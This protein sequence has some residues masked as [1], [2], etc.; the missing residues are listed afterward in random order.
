MRNLVLLFALTGLAAAPL[1]AQMQDDRNSWDVKYTNGIAAQVEEQ[2]ITLEEL[3]R[4]VSPLIPEIRNRART[5]YEFD[6]Y[7]SQ[8]TREILQN[9]VDRALIVRDFNERGYQIPETY[10]QNEYDDYIIKEFNGDRSEFLEFLRMQGKSDLQ[11]RQELKERLIVGFMRSEMQKSQT[12]VSPQ[13]IR[14]YY[15]KNR[16]RFYEE[17]AVEVRM[18][19]L[20]PLAYES[21]D[22]MRQQADAIV[23]KL[24]AGED[25]AELAKKYSQ[26]D[27]RNDGGDWGW[28]KRDEMLTELADVAFNIEPGNYSGVIEQGDNLFIIK[29]ED[30]RQEGIQDIEKVRNDI[31]LAITQQLARQAAEKWL[32]RLRKKAYIKY[33][34]EEAGER[35]NDTS[36]VEMNIGSGKLKP[37]DD[38]DALPEKLGPRRPGQPTPGM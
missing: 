9:L 15:E 19:T 12:E 11:F 34:L 7:V 31:E 16:S 20:T 3:R 13:K 5:R 2:I 33:F 14:D 36:P 21:P 35:R 27:K 32:E 6:R 10:L 38:T 4:E 37:E 29:V 17:A 1:A 30:K 26:D 24:A 8:V 22:L 25:F 28:I 23:A 18:I